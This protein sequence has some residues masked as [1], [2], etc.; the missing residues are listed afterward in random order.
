MIVKLCAIDVGLKRIGVA[1]SVFADIVT[2]QEPIL[3]KN[4]DQAANDVD[5]FLSDN[6][7]DKL[8]VGYPTSSV[9]MQNRIKHF[10]G[11]LK[12]DGDKVFVEE[13]MSSIEAEEQTKGI[14]K[15]KRDGKIDSIAA[16]I[17]LKRYLGCL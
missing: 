14:I 2:P 10:V 13:D 11:L 7:I 4:R 16:S 9:D 12:F 17:I 6:G 15:H 8:I 5:K 1:T 3:R